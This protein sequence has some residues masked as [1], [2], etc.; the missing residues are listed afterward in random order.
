MIRN[1]LVKEKNCQR[2]DPWLGK[3]GK[4][5]KDGGVSES[6]GKEFRKKGGDKIRTEFCARKPDGE[7]PTCLTPQKQGIGV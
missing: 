3:R 1:H 7:V 4:K 6:Q 5:K 2:K